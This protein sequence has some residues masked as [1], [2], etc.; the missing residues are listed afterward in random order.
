MK[1]FGEK[2]RNCE[3]VF[4]NNGPF[5]HVCTPGALSAQIFCD[6]DDFRFAVNLLARCVLDSHGV[7]LVAYA[8]MGNHVHLVMSGLNADVVS[9]FGAFRKRLSRYI[10]GTDRFADLASFEPSCLEIKTLTALRNTISYVHRNGYLIS[11]DHTP[12]S[13]PWSSGRF[14]FNDIKGEK[15]YCTLS[16]IEK[17][18][19]FRARDIEMPTDALLVNEHIYPSVFCD[20]NLGMSVFRDAHHYYLSLFRNVEAYSAIAESIGDSEFMTDSEAYVH[21]SRLARSRFQN[22]SLRDLSK[23]QRLELAKSLHYELKCSNGQIRRILGLQI[24]EVD[25]MFPKQSI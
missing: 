14:Y 22:Q 23:Y 10:A 24:E 11:C 4:F 9:F 13:Y 5:W 18:R 16:T 25:A 20:L 17:R 12:F 15:P 21:A 7:G 3:A 6:D 8:I 19:M 2:E 1:T